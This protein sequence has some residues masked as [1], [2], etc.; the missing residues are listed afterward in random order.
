MQGF[1]RAFRD[2]YDFVIA[3]GENAAGGAGHNPQ[4]L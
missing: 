3:N 4:A 1:L 2:D